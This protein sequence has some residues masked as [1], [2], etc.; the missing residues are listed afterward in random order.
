M[1]ENIMLPEVL[2]H[3]NRLLGV[4]NFLPWEFWETVM[5]DIFVIMKEIHGFHTL[6]TQKRSSQVFWS[7]SMKTE[8][9]VV[10]TMSL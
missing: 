1:E 7:K 9:K 10:V 5:A 6:E 4:E 3:W 8:T 2:T